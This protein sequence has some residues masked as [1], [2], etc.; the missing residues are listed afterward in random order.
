MKTTILVTLLILAIRGAPFVRIADADE[1]FY[2]I[3]STQQT[4]IVSFDSAGN[5]EWTN[6]IAPSVCGVQRT[7]GLDLSWEPHMDP[8]VVT[9]TTTHVSAENQVTLR[10]V[11]SGVKPRRSVTDE[12]EA[13]IEVAGRGG[14][15]GALY[16]R[17]EAAC[18]DAVRV[19]HRRRESAGDLA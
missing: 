1:L 2:R 17:A 18:G 19:P 14:P 3:T 6:S 12:P 8:L 16:L 5:I 4:G 10:N 9:A 11:V 13:E 15:F 7:P